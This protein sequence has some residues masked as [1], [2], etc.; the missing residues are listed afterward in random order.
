MSC[1][2]VS[3]N[4]NLGNFPLPSSESVELWFGRKGSV[5]YC[6]AKLWQE[7]KAISSRHFRIRYDLSNRAFYLLDER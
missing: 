2:L 4:P 5:D 1:S 3:L 6:K 7:T